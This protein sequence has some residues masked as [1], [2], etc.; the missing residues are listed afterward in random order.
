MTITDKICLHKRTH[1]N[2]R[3]KLQTLKP[4]KGPS[5]E[6]QEA[7]NY[8]LHIITVAKRRV[9]RTFVP[10]GRTQNHIGLDKRTQPS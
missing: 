2:A 9:G 10:P 6:Q 3:R 7:F 8:S 5:T 4:F 1:K